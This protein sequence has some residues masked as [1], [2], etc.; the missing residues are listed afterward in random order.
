M[1]DGLGHMVN[2]AL[3]ILDF[4]ETL[5]QS[6]GQQE[7]FEILPNLKEMGVELCIASRNHRYVVEDALKLHS[8]RHLL[9][10]VMADFRPKVFQIKHILNKYLLREVQFGRVLFVD[11]YLPNIHLVRR[12]LPHIECFQFGVDLKHLTE[13][14]NLV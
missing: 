7:G 3:V 1:K 2:R 13:L 14:S 6:E 4:D 12:E 10:Y 9:T 8:I 5:V 11:D